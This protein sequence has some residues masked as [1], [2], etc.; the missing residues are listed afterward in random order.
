MKIIK[1]FIVPILIFFLLI[2]CQKD[3]LPEITPQVTTLEAK[4]YAIGGVSLIGHFDNFDENSTLGFNLFEDYKPAKTILLENPKK[5]ENSIKIKYG[6]QSK[7]KYY[8]EAFIID[9][10]EHYV[11]IRKSF[12]S[13]GSVDINITGVN[14]NEVQFLDEIT[15]STKNDILVNKPTDIKIS[16]NGISA[17]IR[18]INSN[19]IRLIVPAIS[20]PIE[21]IEIQYFGKKVVH[22]LNIKL[23]EPKISSISNDKPTFEEIITINGKGFQTYNNRKFSVYIDGIHTPVLNNTNTAISVKVPSE[24]ISK[25]PEIII[26]SNFH[27]K[28]FKNTFS[29]ASP[30]I[31]SVPNGVHIFETIEITGK[32]FHPN[33]RKNKVFFKDKYVTPSHLSTQNRLQVDVPIGVYINHKTEIKVVISE[34]VL[35][36]T[37]ELTFLDSFEVVKDM[38]KYIIHSTFEVA[39]VN[40]IYFTDINKGKKTIAKYNTT[41]HE[42]YDKITPHGLTGSSNHLVDETNKEVYFFFK[43]DWRHVDN[44]CKLNLITNKIIW[45]QA[46]I[47]YN[48]ENAV[49]TSDHKIN[50]VADVDDRRG[51]KV[52]YYFEYSILENKWTKLE[53]ATDKPPI[54]SAFKNTKN[55]YISSFSATKLLYYFEDSKFIELDSDVP[56]SFKNYNNIINN[57]H[58]NKFYFIGLHPDI[59]YDL[60]TFDATRN[61]WKE[62]NEILPKKLNVKNFFVLENTIYFYCGT[63]TNVGDYNYYLIKQNL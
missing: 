38:N 17:E 13:T 49:F 50:A 11:G 41:T 9:K 15:L 27:T 35:T 22:D 48:I 54:H 33:Y 7:S 16:F 4:T 55:A 25:K 61:I 43:G 60:M 12:E 46:Y 37:K 2:S 32:N 39:G 24:L 63:Y 47:G 3:E 6:L 31:S 29:I 5:G 14:K 57:H 21:N 56:L 53:K 8:Y 58:N 44:F 59:D 34:E 10:E 23:A 42:F 28:V 19:H 45:L 20:K 1:I 36:E 18:N 30:V 62:I 52:P 26:N 51:E 40:Y